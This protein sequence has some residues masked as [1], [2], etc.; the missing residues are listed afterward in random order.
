MFQIKVAEYWILYKAPSSTRVVDHFQNEHTIIRWKGSG[1]K[2]LVRTTAKK[3]EVKMAITANP[4]LSVCKLSMLVHVF[5]ASTHG[6]LQELKLYLYRFSV[7][8]ALRIPD[9]DNYSIRPR[10]FFFFDEAW[11]HLDGYMNSQNYRFWASENPEAFV[12]NGIHPQKIGIWRAIS[13][14]YVV[15]PLLLSAT[16]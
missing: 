7:R 3:E 10:F 14:R 13:Y 12:E 4:C 11:V 15:G 5:R 6:L 16:K 1:R 9:Y 8:Q 2:K